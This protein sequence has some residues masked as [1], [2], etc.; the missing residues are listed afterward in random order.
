MSC[1]KH[2]LVRRPWLLS[3]SCSTQG[4]VN[5]T[6]LVFCVEGHHQTCLPLQESLT[7]HYVVTTTCMPIFK[8]MLLYFP[9]LYC[10]GALAM[11]HLSCH[12][13]PLHSVSLPWHIPAIDLLCLALTGSHWQMCPWHRHMLSIGPISGCEC[14]VPLVHK[15]WFDDEFFVRH[16]VIYRIVLKKCHVSPGTDYPNFACLPGIWPIILRKSIARVIHPSMYVQNIFLYQL[17]FPLLLSYSLC[18][19]THLSCWRKLPVCDLSNCMMWG[20][21]RHKVQQQHL[22]SETKGLSGTL[23]CSTPPFFFKEKI[24]N[25]WVWSYGPVW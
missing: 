5:Y 19:L 8:G 1:S 20:T 21:T 13:I 16:L 22:T 24:S 10:S 23:S 9:I 2:I 14:A 7:T 18:N 12:M 17:I 3:V 15:A 25:L 11:T 4:V 6:S